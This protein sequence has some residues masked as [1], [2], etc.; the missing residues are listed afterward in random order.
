MQRFEIAKMSPIILGLTVVLLALPLLFLGIG[1][2]APSPAS[3]FLVPTGALIAVLYAGIWLWSRPSSFEVGPAGLRV[4]W[5]VR[6][7][8]IPRHNVAAARVMDLAS[9]RSEFGNTLRV[10]AG[11]LFGTFGW[12]W[13][14][15]AGLLDVYV[16]NL[17]PW[18]IVERRVG[19]PLVLSPA[20]PDG[21]ASALV[22]P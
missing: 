1:L 7:L 13:S 2:A 22:N 21:F 15:R 10:G 14:R 16:T 20:N 6:S 3:M 4:V 11:G 12:L 5:P 18:V 19:R 17:G 9:F 8:S